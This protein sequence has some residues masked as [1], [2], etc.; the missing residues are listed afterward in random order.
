MGEKSTQHSGLGIGRG[1]GQGQGLGQSRKGEPESQKGQ[2]LKGRGMKP[3]REKGLGSSSTWVSVIVECTPSLSAAPTKTKRPGSNR[4]QAFCS[5]R[6]P[7]RPLF[8]RFV[9][10]RRCWRS[11]LAAAAHCLDAGAQR[12][13]HHVE[14]PPHED[15]H[16][17][18]EY[19]GQAVTCIVA[20]AFS[21]LDGK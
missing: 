19:H 3:E 14:R 1:Q 4:H 10:L 9:L 15:Q 17:N 2:S 7:T 8:R 13:S 11:R 21:E 12:N 5:P 16:D 18:A 20:E 6:V